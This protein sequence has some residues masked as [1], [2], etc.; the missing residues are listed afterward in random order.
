M[1]AFSKNTIWSPNTI[2]YI[3]F[4]CILVIGI[5]ALCWSWSVPFP[6]C[7]IEQWT[8]A[9]KLFVQEL[10]DV[11]KWSLGLSTGL[12]GL[13]ASLALG[14]KEGPKFSS[15]AWM[16]LFPVMCCLALSSYFAL[17]WRTGVAE[18]YLNSCPQLMMSG[19]VKVRFDLMTYF[20]LGGLALMAATLLS[21]MFER[22]EKGR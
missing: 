16:L 20:Y 9:Q 15:T 18:A 22:T 21:T 8:D 17:M 14:L 1:Q 10:T 11:A 2:T 19:R 12:I 3:L 5:I 6:A 4:G 13:F 7:P